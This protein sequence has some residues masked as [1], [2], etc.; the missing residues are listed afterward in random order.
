MSNRCPNNMSEWLSLYKTNDNSDHESECCTILCCPI[1]TP[2][3]L[4]ILPC[5]FY[6]MC[7]N[8]IN[9]KYIC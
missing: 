6:N 5:T 3:L 2:I 9:N 7:M 1:K 4:L 8:K